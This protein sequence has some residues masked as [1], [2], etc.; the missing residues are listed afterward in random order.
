VKIFPG[1]IGTDDSFDFVTGPSLAHQF[2]QDRPES[3]RS[4]AIGLEI[5]PRRNQAVPG[6]D[7]L[8][9]ELQRFRNRIRP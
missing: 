4:L 2:G 1:E 3:D 9:F 7:G 8:E 5:G 6:N